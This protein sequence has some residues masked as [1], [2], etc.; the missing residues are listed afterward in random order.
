MTTRQD[1]FNV[2]LRKSSSSFVPRSRTPTLS[3]TQYTFLQRLKLSTNLRISIEILRHSTNRVKWR[4]QHRFQA[5]PSSLCAYPRN[6][7]ERYLLQTSRR[8]ALW[9]MRPTLL[10]QSP[11]LLPHHQRLLTR[12]TSPRAYGTNTNMCANCHQHWQLRWPQQ[13]PRQQNDARRSRIRMPKSRLQ[14]LRCAR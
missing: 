10:S 12:S 8:R 11:P 14:T 2:A 5:L 9:I 3:Q 4:Q 13:R 6:E 1:F 7:Q